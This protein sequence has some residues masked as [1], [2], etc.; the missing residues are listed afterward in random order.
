MARKRVLK[1]AAQDPVAKRESL[2][3]K[4]KEVQETSKG[5]SGKLIVAAFVAGLVGGMISLR[6]LKLW[7][8]KT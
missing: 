4:E 1:D 5:G 7:F 6:F 8:L 2:K 3:G